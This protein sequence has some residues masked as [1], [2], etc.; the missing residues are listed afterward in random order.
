MSQVDISY[1][2]LLNAIIS[3]GYI[4]ETE[5]RPGIKCQQINSVNLEL[6]LEKLPLLTTKEMHWKSIVTELIW[7][8]R[9]ESN[10]KYLLDHGV[11]IWNKDAY[12]FYER[13][14]KRM[15]AKE[16]LGFDE[17]IAFAKEE[18]T[19][20]IIGE[21]TKKR[22]YAGY[23]GINYG[24]QWRYWPDPDSDENL[25]QLQ[26]LFDN[27]SRLNPISRRHI[28]TAW[29]P[30]EL[31][32]TAL[33]PCHWS[34]EIIPRPLN[35][36]DRINFCHPE[37]QEHLG[38]LWDEMAKGNE[39]AE[40]KLKQSLADIPK[41]SMILKWHQRS[42]DTFL[43]LPFNIA[44]YAVLASFIGLCTEMIA[45]HI[46]GDLSNVHLYGPHIDVAKEQIQRNPTTYG[47]P[48]LSFSDRLL[49]DVDRYKKGK[50]SFEKLIKGLV[51]E[52]FMLENYE[53]FGKLKADM[54]E[55][56]K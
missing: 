7:F 26:V 33:P 2:T 53:S 24:V 8:L 35:Y 11:N 56:T 15:K 37:D 54:F 49:E 5:N 51:P 10:I 40:R 16:I 18:R 45:T 4:Y 14:A 47:G 39:E 12:R 48:D 1:N 21:L 27:L 55:E 34:W 28:V 46:I 31:E 19:I 9:G 41:Y 3:S 36:I 6:S 22:F 38:K 23:V 44:S 25:D 17:Y 52:D 42:V 50:L 13:T 43:G 20:E 29:N 32:D 30:A